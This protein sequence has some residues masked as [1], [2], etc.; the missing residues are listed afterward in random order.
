MFG[1]L[2]CNEG[3]LR[4]APLQVDDYRAPTERVALAA[5]RRIDE[6]DAAQRADPPGAAVRVVDVPGDDEARPRAGDVPQERAAPQLK[7]SISNLTLISQPND[8]TF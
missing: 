5:V 4:K 2:P 3:A 8:Q 1:G 7:G 6:L